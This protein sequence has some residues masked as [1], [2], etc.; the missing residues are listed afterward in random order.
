MN[1][2]SPVPDVVDVGI[3]EALHRAVLLED[4]VAL[5]ELVPTPQHPGGAD[6]RA[7]AL[8]VGRQPIA[9][10]PIPRRAADAVENP[11]FL[12][13]DQGKR[14]PRT[15]SIRPAIDPAMSRTGSRSRRT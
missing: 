13:V 14:R 6:V 9:L 2:I 10:H 15:T 1:G 7:G 8:D 3:A 5:V 4:H 11:V 12:D